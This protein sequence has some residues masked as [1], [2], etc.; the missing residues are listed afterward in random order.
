MTA[1]AMDS[2]KKKCLENGMD[3]YISKPF[4]LEGLNK[5]ITKYIR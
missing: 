4:N 3:D 2:D 1:Y 5:I